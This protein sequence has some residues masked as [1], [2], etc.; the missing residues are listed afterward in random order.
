VSLSFFAADEEDD[1]ADESRLRCG[2]IR[3]SN[4]LSVE[5][6]LKV[7]AFRLGLRATLATCLSVSS[8]DML[9]CVSC[10]AYFEATSDDFSTCSFE[11]R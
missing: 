10:R 1:I 11:L 7:D 9:L 4:A 3:D 6:R 2:I 8:A 5:S